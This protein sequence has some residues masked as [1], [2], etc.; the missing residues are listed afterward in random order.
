MKKENSSWTVGFLALPLAIADKL[1][2]PGTVFWRHPMKTTFYPSFDYLYF[3]PYLLYILT[4]QTP[5]TD[6]PS[7]MNPV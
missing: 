1:S 5:F 4:K 6:L 2:L 3:Q 7:V